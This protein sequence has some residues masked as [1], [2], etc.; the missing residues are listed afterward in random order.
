[1]NNFTLDGVLYAPN[2][3]ITINANN[4]TI[5]GSAAGKQFTVSANN[6]TVDRTG[7]PITTLP[8][9]NTVQLVE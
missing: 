3:K 8:G 9:N 2:G 5:N 4:V 6:I 1:G 7:N